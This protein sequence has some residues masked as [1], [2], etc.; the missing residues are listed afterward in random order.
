[1]QRTMVEGSRSIPTSLSMVGNILGATAD[2]VNAVRSLPGPIWDF[3]LV[4]HNAEHHD[5]LPLNA[6]RNKVCLPC[7]YQTML[8]AANP[9]GYWDPANLTPAPATVKLP[10]VDETKSMPKSSFNGSHT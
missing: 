6:R 2:L 10:C 9:S 5:E 7:A 3:L 4:P 8:D 1:M